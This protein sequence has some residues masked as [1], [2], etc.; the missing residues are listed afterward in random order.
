MAHENTKYTLPSIIVTPIDL[1]RLQ[2][3]LAEVDDFLMQA[4]LRTPGEPIRMPKASRELDDIAKNYSLN[5]LDKSDRQ[6]L[7]D[8]FSKVKKQAP[9]LHVSFAT[10]PPAAFLQKLISW[11]RREIHPLI[12]VQIGLQPSIAA[13]CTVRTANRYFDF[14]LRRHLVARRDVLIKRLKEEHAT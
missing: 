8:E 10:E 2:R 5:I 12:L 11:L 7:M 6:A 4:N 14:S 3:E 9:V 1:G 13:G